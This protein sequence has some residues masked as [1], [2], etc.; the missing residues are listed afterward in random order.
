ML[1]KIRQTLRTAFTATENTLENAG[2]HRTNMV[3]CV[4]ALEKMRIQFSELRHD[5]RSITDLLRA[6]ADCKKTLK[7]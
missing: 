4:T 5:Q 3:A 7:A 2:I 1:L 6:G